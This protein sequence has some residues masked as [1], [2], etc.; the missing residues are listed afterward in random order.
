M[1]VI[2]YS[3]SLYD[4][5]HLTCSISSLS[6]STNSTGFISLF[7]LFASKKFFSCLYLPSKF[8]FAS[9][10]NLKAISTTF[11][12]SLKL[13]VSFNIFLYTPYGTLFF[14]ST[15]NICSCSVASC[16]FILLALFVNAIYFTI[17]G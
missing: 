3:S 1:Y 15:I 4:N 2:S 11:W 12:L 17:L 10:L 13:S 16:I 9:S 8:I 14:S 6:S 7:I 5:A